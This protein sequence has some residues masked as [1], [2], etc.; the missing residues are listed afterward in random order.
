MI[1]PDMQDALAA[2]DSVLLNEQAS[3]LKACRKALDEL[4]ADKPLAAGWRYG[5]TT[6]GNLKVELHDY[7]PQGVFN[8][9][10]NG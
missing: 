6:L 5:R 10:S 1:S 3:L 7:R 4:I 2:G 9:D 8:G